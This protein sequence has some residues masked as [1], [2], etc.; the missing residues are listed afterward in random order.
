MSFIK[1]IY[2]SL[3]GAIHSAIISLPFFAKTHNAQPILQNHISGEHLDK[4]SLDDELV[5]RFREM[6][7]R[8]EDY[9]IDVEGIMAI[10]KRPVIPIRITAVA[11]TPSKTLSRK[12]WSIMF[13]FLS[14][15]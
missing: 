6:G 14:C 13:L 11:K 7:V 10:S 8:V 9:A 5:A 3:H 12:P 15:L 2:L 4:P 1:Q